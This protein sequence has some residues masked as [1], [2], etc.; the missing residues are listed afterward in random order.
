MGIY[1]Y[2]HSVYSM[3]RPLDIA[4]S[5]SDVWMQVILIG[6][7]IE[8]YKSHDNKNNNNKLYK[9]TTHHAE[10]GVQHTLIALF[11]RG[12]PSPTII[13]WFLI[14]PVLFQQYDVMPQA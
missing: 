8:H 2:T 6:S 4:L 14:C 5:Y 11:E 3:D 9:K 7:C 1:Y 10:V 13:G 12:F